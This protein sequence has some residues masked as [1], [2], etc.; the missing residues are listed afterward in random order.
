MT[1]TDP[2]PPSA[3]SDRELDIELANLVEQMRHDHPILYHADGACRHTR[4]FRCES[5]A[6]HYSTDHA[7]AAQAVAFVLETG[8]FIEVDA[9]AGDWRVKFICNLTDGLND[10]VSLFT[11]QAATEPRAKAEAALS[12]LRVMKEK[13]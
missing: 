11:A 12:A 13:G 10:K 4:C 3:L 7:A 9:S 6:P 1:T 2:A 8:A 5:S